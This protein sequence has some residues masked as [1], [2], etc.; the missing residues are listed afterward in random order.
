MT[1]APGV[2]IHEHAHGSG[3]V[4]SEN[5]RPPAASR[6]DDDRVVADSG[7]PA[8]KTTRAP[9]DRGAHSKTGVKERG[10]LNQK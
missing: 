10:K 3:N 4:T 8:P 6:T 9:D 7:E 2:G 5:A 1:V